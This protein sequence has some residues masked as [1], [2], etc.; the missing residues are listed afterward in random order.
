MLIFQYHILKQKKR[1]Q[2]AADC[3]KAT[4]EFLYFKPLYEK[5]VAADDEKESLSIAH[6]ALKYRDPCMLAIEKSEKLHKRYLLDNEN[7]LGL[8]VAAETTF[9]FWFLLHLRGLV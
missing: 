5:A 9:W 7:V 1:I 8:L 3:D 2:V 6:M 4:D